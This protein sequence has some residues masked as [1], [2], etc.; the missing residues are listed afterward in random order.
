MS[1]R[2]RTPDTRVRPA[3]INDARPLGAF[4]IQSWKESGPGALGFA[5]ATDEAIKE[6]ASEAFLVKRLSSPNT[7]IVVAER[8]GR[9]LGFASVRSTGEREAELSG[10]VVLEG[11]AGKG[12]GT[13]LIR[14]AFDAAVKL[15][16]RILTVKT[17]AVNAR[18]IGFYEKNG[19]TRTSR[20][21]EKIG[22][23]RVPIQVLEK[24][25]R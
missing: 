20:T 1:Q 4:F 23:T 5:G 15:G 12:L 18:A 25:L 3:R 24:R 7:K 13:R 14:K 22:R 16:F 9:I 6:I 2:P 17:E 8:E 10:I 11:E 19:F 21:T